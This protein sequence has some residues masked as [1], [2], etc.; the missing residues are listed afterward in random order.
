MGLVVVL[1]LTKAGD[2][3]FREWRRDFDL[4]VGISSSESESSSA[5]SAQRVVMVRGGKDCGR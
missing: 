5:A 4:V 1:F 2:A 3:V